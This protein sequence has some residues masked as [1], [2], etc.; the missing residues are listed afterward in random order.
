MLQGDLFEYQNG[1][2]A[3]VEKGILHSE[4][5]RNAWTAVITRHFH[6]R[7]VISVTRAYRK[8][9]IRAKFIRDNRPPHSYFAMLAELVV[10]GELCTCSLVK[11]ESAQRSV[12]DFLASYWHP[13]RDLGGCIGLT[14]PVLKTSCV[15]CP[16]SDS[17][18][19]IPDKCGL[20]L[21]LLQRDWV[22][23]RQVSLALQM[24]T[25]NVL[26]DLIASYLSV[27]RAPSAPPPNVS[28]A[29]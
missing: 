8:G 15:Q 5:A 2:N 11:F 4:C 1:L 6:H 13:R 25:P 20:C 12:L 17:V 7:D 3:A 18:P 26:A 10:L 9:W 21:Q 29:F 14:G 16:I 28:S 27:F 23:R 24:Y 19:L 22:I